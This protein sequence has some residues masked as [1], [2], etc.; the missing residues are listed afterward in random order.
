MQQQPTDVT[1]ISHKEY[2]GPITSSDL[3]HSALYLIIVLD[4]FCG[5]WSQY[6][7]ALN[8]LLTQPNFDAYRVSHS[9]NRDRKNFW[10]GGHWANKVFC[11]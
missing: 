10:G 2:V 6:P 5:A 3:L 4:L 11:I 1:A 9:T 8:N 7:C